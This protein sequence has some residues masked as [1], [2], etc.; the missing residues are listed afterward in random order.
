MSN[1]IRKSNFLKIENVKIKKCEN[2]L[3]LNWN[4]GIFFCRKKI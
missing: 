2:H 4:Y 1:R 3:C